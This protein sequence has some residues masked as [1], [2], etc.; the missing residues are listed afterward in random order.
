M[1]SRVPRRLIASDVEHDQLIEMLVGARLVTSDDGVLEITHEA[2][3]RAWPRLRGWLDDDVE[4][5]RMLHHL[6]SAADSWDSLGRPDSELYRGI[7]LARVLDWQGQQADRPDGHRARVPRRVPACRGGRGAHR[8][9]ARQDPGPTD[10]PAARRARRGRRPPGRWLWRRGCWRSGR[11]AGRR[12]TLPTR[13]RRRQVRT[14]GPPAPGH[15]SP[16]TSTPRCSWPLPAS[17]WT[18]RRRPGAVCS[19]PWPSTRRSS[20]RCRWP[21]TRFSTS[22]SVRTVA[23]S[24][25]MTRRTGCAS[26]RSTPGSASRSS[27]PGRPTT[28]PGWPGT[29]SSA[30]TDP[31]SRS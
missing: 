14:R 5:Q 6:S 4:G 25:P 17:A 1:R 12:R 2:L 31:R 19:P 29:S 18:T 11:V 20:P 8:R 24:R 26:T 7:R 9:R 27:R 30:P 22:T 13:S 3:A 21:A 10:P 16:T 15:W 28:C 23:R